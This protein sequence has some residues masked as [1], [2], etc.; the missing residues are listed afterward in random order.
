[1]T[2]SAD[3]NEA[4]SDM[5]E[6]TGMP[7]DLKGAADALQGALGRLESALNPILSRL[8][9]LEQQVKDADVFKEDRAKLAKKLDDITAREKEMSAQ[10][11]A[12]ETEFR[13]LSD[14]TT[15]ELEDAIKHMRNALS[16]SEES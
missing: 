10:I 13:E 2:D 11:E 12:R 3:I 5:D 14:A 4:P 8:T 1:M 7:V 16:Q 6:A 15:R 9:A